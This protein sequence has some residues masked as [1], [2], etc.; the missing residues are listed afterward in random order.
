M[1]LPLTS[2]QA[3]VVYDSMRKLTLQQQEGQAA[4]EGAEEEEAPA[5]PDEK[6]EVK[7]PRDYVMGDNC[8]VVMQQVGAG[9]C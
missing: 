8:H 5:E 7:V 1:I 9:L 4:A 3:S 2:T 6:V